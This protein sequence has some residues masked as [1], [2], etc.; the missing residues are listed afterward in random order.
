[1]WLLGAATVLGAAAGSALLVVAGVLL[2]HA[3]LLRAGRPSAARLVPVLAVTGVAAEIV[4]LLA[5]G[6]GVTEAALSVASL[7]ALAAGVALLRRLPAAHR[8]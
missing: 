8:V 3:V 4:R 6:G 5:S 1:M 2:P 7:L